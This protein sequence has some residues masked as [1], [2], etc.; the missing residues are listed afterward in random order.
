[1]GTYHQAVRNGSIPQLR[2]RD[3]QMR[4]RD[5]ELEIA[6]ATR[7]LADKLK[8]GQ[9]VRVSNTRTITADDVAEHADCNDLSHD[10][11]CDQLAVQF[12]EQWAY[13]EWVNS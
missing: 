1:M 9:N 13:H 11:A 10:E 8:A 6:K 7:E 12:V 3:R 2:E 4:G 5:L